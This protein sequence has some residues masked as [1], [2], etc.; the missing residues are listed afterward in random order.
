M[1]LD[2]EMRYSMM[3]KLVLALIN[4]KKKLKQYFESHPITVYTGYPIR[5]ILAKPDL[6]ERLTK[7]AIEL[8]TYDI[9]YLPRI[10]NKGQ[11]LADLFSK[12]L[13]IQL[14]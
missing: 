5:Q 9:S 13:V 6:S 14:T 1:L 8:G 12:N 7:W 3:E 10:T 2:T 4:A 11:V